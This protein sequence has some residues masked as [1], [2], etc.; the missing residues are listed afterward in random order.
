MIKSVRIGDNLIGPDNPCFVIAEAGVNHNGDMDLAFR[1]IDAAAEAGADAVKFQSF[2]TEELVTHEAPKANYQVRTTKSDDI[3]QFAMLKALE[4][5]AAQQLKLKNHCAASNIL[6]LCTPYE[7]KSIDL[8]D[9]LDVA[10]FKIASTDTTN[11]PMLRHIAAK[12]RPILLSTGMCTLGEIESAMEA[13]NPVKNKIVLLQCTSEYPAP[14]HEVNLRAIKTMAQA[15]S[16]PVGFSDHTPAIGA[17][18]WAVALGACIIEKHFTLDRS[19]EGP[20]HKASLE[21]EELSE[22]VKTVRAVEE[23]MGDGRKRPMPSE[24]ANKEKMRKSLVAQVDIKAGQIIKKKHL[25]CKR[26]GTGLAPAW[27]DKVVNKTAA[28]DIPADSVLTLDSIQWDN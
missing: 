16:C 26:P 11:I 17:S 10:A 7:H 13:L 19:M 8:L 14:M 27:M 20:D 28:K 24:A 9:K 2:I 1:L 22:L 23:A 12:D 6:Y 5:D 25:T 3:G 21:P 18:P 15:F 4:L